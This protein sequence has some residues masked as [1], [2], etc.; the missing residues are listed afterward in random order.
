MLNILYT[1]NIENKI[2]INLL[3]RLIFIKQKR[4]GVVRV[5]KKKKAVKKKAAKK[6]TTKRKTAK[7]KKR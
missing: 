6:R 2:A 7:K 4:K 5:A 1:E 3:K